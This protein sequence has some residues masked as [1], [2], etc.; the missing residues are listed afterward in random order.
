MKSILVTGGA[1]YIGSHVVDALCE[2]NKSVIV[3]DNLSSGF[4]ENLNPKATFILG[5][6]TNKEDLNDLFS[7][8]EFNSVIHMAALKSVAGSNRNLS[9]YAEN[10]IFGSLNV[11][12]KAIEYGIDK[13][14]FSSTA[15]VYGDPL[16][17]PI[18]ED[19]QLNPIN[20][21][22]FT[23][24]YVENYLKWMLRDNRMKF[25]NLRYFNAA[26]YSTKPNLIKHIENNPQN[27]LPKIMETFCGISSSIN[28]YGNK[29]PTKDG[30]CVRDY[31]HVV[32]IANAHLDAIKYLDKYSST[33]IN[34]SNG[35]GY[36]VLEIINHA[37]NI[38]KKDLMYNFTAAREGDPAILIA[39]NIKA[40]KELQW[41]AKLSINII[42]ESMWKIYSKINK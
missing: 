31:I 8:Y 42:I 22:G 6:F 18:D 12:N 10:N 28:I 1:G 40:N 13:F 5:D 9:I 14:I 4:K 29:Y 20:F 3:Y 32:D 19:H 2:E 37:Q 11:I 36:S 27:L 26:G 25:V 38:T 7:N 21:Y 15:A 17:N 33:S 41:K 30:T 39:S 16:Y 34:L 23:K 24:L 35:Y